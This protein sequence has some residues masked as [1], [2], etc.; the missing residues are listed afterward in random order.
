MIIDE[1]CVMCEWKRKISGA[2]IGD[3]GNLLGIGRYWQ[4][5]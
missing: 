3:V 5:R 2:F 4:I 1:R